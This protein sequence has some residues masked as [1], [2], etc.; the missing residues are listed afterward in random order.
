MYNVQPRDSMP[1]AQMN[2]TPIAS[3]PKFDVSQIFAHI[4]QCVCQVSTL[5]GKSTGI[6]IGGNRVVVPFHV[7]ELIQIENEPDQPPGTCRYFVPPITVSYAET[8]YTADWIALRSLDSHVHLDTALFNIRDEDFLPRPFLQKY[9]PSPS[10]SKDSPLPRV[11]EKIYYAGYPL[12]HA[13]PSFH[14]GRVSSLAEE[15]GTFT[16]DATVLPGNS[17]APVFAQYGSRL[18]LVGMIIAELANIDPSLKRNMEMLANHGT[19]NKPMMLIGTVDYVTTISDTIEVMFANF[20]TGIGKVIG[21]QQVQNLLDGTHKAIV[22][23]SPF[24]QDFHVMKG[25]RMPGLLAGDQI[26]QRF[27]HRRVKANPT[28]CC[29]LFGRVIEANEHI[30]AEEEQNCLR[31]YYE[32][33]IRSGNMGCEGFQPTAED[34]FLILKKKIQAANSKGI[35]QH[36]KKWVELLRGHVWPESESDATLRHKRNSAIDNLLGLLRKQEHAFD[37]PLRKLIEDLRL[38]VTLAGTPMTDSAF[39]SSSSAPPS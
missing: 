26:Y 4:S 20:A 38:E 35:K 39:S 13:Q 11:G 9:L 6:L 14:K 19:D 34:K 10:L 36:A 29:S 5:K 12:N 25:E 15:E 7:L 32:D 8:T 18:Y 30:T 3:P 1:P 28:L 37:A 33:C 24:Q 31:P 2:L 16:I 23:P 22:G 27:Y 17:G 21:I